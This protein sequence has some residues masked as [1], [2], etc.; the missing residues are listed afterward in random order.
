M[1]LVMTTTVFGLYRT[2]PN[3]VEM[4][5]SSREGANVMRAMF[6]PAWRVRPLTAAE[7]ATPWVQDEVA[8]MTE[9]GVW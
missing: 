9:A 2:D 6:G 3:A 7:A 4:I 8:A 5:A 1:V